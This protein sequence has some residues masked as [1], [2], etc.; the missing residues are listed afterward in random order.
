MN[1]TLQRGRETGGGGGGGVV[2]RRRMG[3]RG[4]LSFDL[5]GDILGGGGIDRDAYEMMY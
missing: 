4:K 3:G 5:R 1:L 2:S